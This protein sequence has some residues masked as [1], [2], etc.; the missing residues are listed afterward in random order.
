MYVLFKCSIDHRVIKFFTFCVLL[1]PSKS[2]HYL[3]R[4]MNYICAT[5]SCGYLHLL[6]RFISPTSHIILV[7]GFN[8]MI[9]ESQNPK[10]VS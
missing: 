5:K 1:I 7:N 8:P 9:S 4:M 6:K 2:S 3:I 10:N